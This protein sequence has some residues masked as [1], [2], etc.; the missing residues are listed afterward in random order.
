MTSGS[1]KTEDLGPHDYVVWNAHGPARD[2]L[3][4]YPYI[5]P[6]VESAGVPACVQGLGARFGIYFGIT[7]EVTQYQDAAWIDGE[8]GYRFI[9]ACFDRSVYFHNCGRPA[10]GHHGFSASHTPADIEE[11]LNRIESALH[12]M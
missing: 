3:P 4:T 12:T 11:S 8:L 9:C 7:R 10:L 6:Q 1:I 2:E 5:P